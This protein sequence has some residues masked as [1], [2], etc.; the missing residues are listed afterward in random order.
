MTL[1]LSVGTE[2]LRLEP[3]VDFHDIVTG[4]L[5]NNMSQG[6]FPQTRRTGQQCH[7]DNERERERES[8]NYWNSSFNGIGM[9][10]NVI[11]K[12]FGVKQ[13]LM[14]SLQADKIKTS[15]LTD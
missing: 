7:L 4:M 12:S 8:I 13:I 14:Q 9:Q 5:C 3:A 11:S 1:K 10:I 15:Q 2:C 6:G